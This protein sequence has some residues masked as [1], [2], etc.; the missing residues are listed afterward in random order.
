[1]T[2][3][4]SLSGVMLVAACLPA[5]GGS[6][7]R[8]SQSESAREPEAE[9]TLTATL[10][11]ANVGEPLEPGTVAL[12]VTASEVRLFTEPP[13]VDAEGRIALDADGEIVALDRLR[14]RLEAALA[15]PVGGPGQDDESPSPA[16]PSDEASVNAARAGE[17]IVRRA[18]IFAD[19]TTSMERIV[20]VSRA[21]SDEAGMSCPAIAARGDAGVLAVA[22]VA[23]T[24]GSPRT[25]RLEVDA[26]LEADAV[27]DRISALRDETEDSIILLDVVPSGAVSLARFLAAAE[28]ATQDARFRRVRISLAPPAPER[29]STGSGYGRAS[30]R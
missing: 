17:I 29:T 1:M 13:P 10:P 2:K 5:C 8:S 3:R 7:A 30:D 18:T 20:E 24:M 12:V 22:P 26:T 23:C 6:E 21:A 9:V 16:E 27:P 4:A 25:A 19:A 14:A 11:R 28:V 15:M